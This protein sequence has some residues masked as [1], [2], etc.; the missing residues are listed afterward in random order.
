MIRY[1]A[2]ISFALALFLNAAPAFAGSKS[3]DDLVRAYRA[4]HLANDQPALATLVY[5]EGVETKEKKLV[6]ASLKEGLERKFESITLIDLPPDQILEYTRNGKTYRPNLKPLKKMQV[7]YQ[8]D[9][10]GIKSTSYLVGEHNGEYYI[11]TAAPIN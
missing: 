4:A 5:W 11:T 2:K 3:L 10:S 6:I 8:D 9:S 1:A 7:T